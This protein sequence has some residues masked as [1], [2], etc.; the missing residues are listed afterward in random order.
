MSIALEKIE[1]KTINIIRRYA[2]VQHDWLMV[3][4][5]SYVKPSIFT[6]TIVTTID[7]IKYNHLFNELD[8][9]RI[10]VLYKN[11]NDDN[12]YILSRFDGLGKK[13][14]MPS[15]MFHEQVTVLSSS[16]YRLKDYKNLV[17]LID[18]SERIVEYTKTNT[19]YLENIGDFVACGRWMYENHGV[20]LIG[21]AQKSLDFLQLDHVYQFNDDDD[22]KPP[23]LAAF[24]MHITV[25]KNSQ[26]L[27]DEDLITFLKKRHIAPKDITERYISYAIL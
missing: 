3:H 14:N 18:H 21:L 26:A 10:F 24:V 17:Y 1:R 20:L 5:R 12:K 13:M 9:R 4:N 27:N 2:D 15:I 7:N 16:L 11:K 6:H 23:T 19:D 22:K 8:P 25:S